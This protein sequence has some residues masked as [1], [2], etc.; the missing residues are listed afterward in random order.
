M[1]PQPMAR[2]CMTTKAILLPWAWVLRDGIYPPNV[3]IAPSRLATQ[4]NKQAA[5]RRINKSQKWGGPLD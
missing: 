4:K 5:G 1:L 2:T 3:L